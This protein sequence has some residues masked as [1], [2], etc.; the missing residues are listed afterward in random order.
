MAI[1][2][3]NTSSFQSEIELSSKF[4]HVNSIEIHFGNGHFRPYTPYTLPLVTQI[5]LVLIPRN[6]FAGYKLPQ[7]LPSAIEVT[8][9]QS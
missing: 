8:F 7:I 6:Q 3:D 2:I 1:Y 9:V 4:Q 5:P